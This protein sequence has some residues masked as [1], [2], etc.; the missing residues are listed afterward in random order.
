MT[1]GMKAALLAS[2]MLVAGPLAAQERLKATWT[3]P[4]DPTT[5]PVT[6]Y[7][8]VLED[9]VE[10]LTGDA[11]DVELYPNGQLGDQRAMVQQ[12][13]RGSLHFANIASGVL[14]S[15]G[16]P[17]LGI[18]DM[19]FLFKSRAHF[20]ATMNRDN[21][22]I[23]KLLDDVAAETGVRV[24]SL[25]PYGFRNMT[26][27][28][29]AV[30]EP[31]DMDGLRMRTMEVVPHQKMMEALGATPVPIPYLELYTSLQTGVVDG[32][33]NP[34]S[35][36]IM[37]RFYQVQGHMTETQHVMTVGAVITNEEWWQGLDE[38]ERKAILAADAEASL[39]HDGIGAVQDLLGVQTLR[40]EG[41]E[42]HTPGPEQMEAFRAATV[43]PTKAWASEQFGEEFVSEFF[44]HMAGFDARF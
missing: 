17:E 20:N 36:I 2:A 27:K 23:A 35:N 13:S 32:Q 21:P 43:E 44:A 3:D 15:L 19:P 30:M 42:V 11:Y 16:Y 6:A 34:P 31:A 22:F 9:Q 8:H 5:A 7:M 29:T 28:D 25:H 37:Q 1:Y 26:T 4:D 14:A 24:I 12:V 41:V 18:V 38:G 39:A 10:R 40:D 33:E